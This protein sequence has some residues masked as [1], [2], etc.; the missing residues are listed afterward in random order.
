MRLVS[1][2]DHDHSRRSR[3]YEGLALDLHSSDPEGLSRMLRA[4]G[5]RVL[6]NVPGHYAHVHV[7]AEGP[8]RMLA[9]WAPLRRP[10]ASAAA[11]H[12]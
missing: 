11:T 7:E 12:D 1:A 2:N 3:H 9:A 5:Y 4:G 8:A 6:W 10:A